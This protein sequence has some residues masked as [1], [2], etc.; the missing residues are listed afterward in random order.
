MRREVYDYMQHGGTAGHQQHHTTRT[1]PAGGAVAEE[2]LLL[3]GRQRAPCRTRGAERMNNGG[4]L[5]ACATA[6]RKAACVHTPLG[7]RQWPSGPVGT[8]AWR[9]SCQ[10][11]VG[12]LFGFDTGRSPTGSVPVGVLPVH[13]TGRDAI[14]T[15]W[16]HACLA[17]AG[18]SWQ[19]ILNNT[20]LYTY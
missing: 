7:S 6:R 14:V 5:T 12:P 4:S 10:V 8:T 15:M 13:L 18:S 1:R 20:S 19:V 11:P 2:T 16:W 17:V 9:S 3:F